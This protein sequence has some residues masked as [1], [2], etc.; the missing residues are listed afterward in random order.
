MGALDDQFR[1][2][3]R[4]QFDDDDVTRC[5]GLSVRAWRELIKRGAVRTSQELGRGRVR[6]CDKVTFMRAAAIASLNRTGL[7]LE[8]S[9]RIAYLLPH[10]QR[11]YSVFNHFVILFHCWEKAD[12]EDLRSRRERPKADWFDPDKPA[13]A[14]PEGDW[15]IEIYDGR[16]VALICGGRKP[17]IFGDLR[18]D[19]TRFVCWWRAHQEYKRVEEVVDQSLAQPSH[20]DLGEFIGKWLHPDLT[21]ERVDPAFLGYEYEDHDAA[22]DPL[23]ISATTAVRNPVFKTTVNISL[24]IRLALRRY[25]GIEPRLATSARGA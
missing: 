15:S 4:N 18:D 11:L 1:R 22:D 6:L 10:D 21:S 20:P 5:T 13:S 9:G 24:A 25:L 3:R 19:A 7:S 23:R 17:L 14:D 12:P 16:F 8:T 2:Y